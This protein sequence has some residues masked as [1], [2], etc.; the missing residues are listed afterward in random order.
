MSKLSKNDTF[1]DFS[2]Y[3]RPIA[4]AAAAR[5][6]HTSATPVQVTI[7]FGIAGLIAVTCILMGY[8]VTAGIFLILKSIIDAMDGELARM[9]K[10]PSYTGRYL[11]SVFDFLLNFIV[12]IAIW[13]VDSNP[14]WAVLLA[15]FCLQ[16]Q[17][18]LYNYYYVI[19]RHHSLEGDRTSKIFETSIPEAYPQESQSTVDTLFKIY[20]LFY[21]SFDKIIYA[22]DRN[23]PDADPFPKWFMS[24]L[25]IYGLGFQLLIMAVFLAT[26]LINLIIPFFILFSGFIFLFIGIRRLYLA[27]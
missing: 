15:F 11:D 4:V 25:S 7:V 3:G 10:R 2:D 19:L 6:K 14:F 1:I 20:R 17:G 9:K 12:L 16:L 24:L 5:L 13:S 26:G 8:Y 22:L 18:T 23:A 21:S 27:G